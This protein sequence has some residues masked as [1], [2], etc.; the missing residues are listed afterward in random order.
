MS[1]DLDI[2]DLTVRFNALTA[3]DCVNLTVPGGTTVGLVGESGSGKSTLARAI[4]GLLR[5]ESGRIHLGGKDIT[6]QRLGHPDR[7]RV[8]LVFQDPAASLDPRMTAGS[9]V[10]QGLLSRTD[11]RSRQRTAEADRMLRLVGLEA[12]LHDSLPRELSGGQRQRVALARALA[13][14]PDVLIAD[15]ITSA[16]DASVQGGVLN[17]LRTLQAELGLTVL[18]ISHNLAA[19]RYVS[20]VVAVM[21]CGQIVEVAPVDRI[22]TAPR[23]PYTASL[24]EAVPTIEDRPS[25][26]VTGLRT[27]AATLA[28]EP[29]DPHQPPSGCRFHPRCPRGPAAHPERVACR[30]SA[31][32]RDHSTGAACFFPLAT[33][34]APIDL[35]R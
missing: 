8:Q 32:T 34:M 30:V 21:Y 31:P 29:A 18:F 26:R 16:L 15:E 12:R 24:L 2:R 27:A 7:R 19:V 3:V 9:A 20:D 35:G 10:K 11:I 4:A 33:P 14:N 23:H 5:P 28:Q 25:H 22:T 6:G 1:T 13:A 17:L